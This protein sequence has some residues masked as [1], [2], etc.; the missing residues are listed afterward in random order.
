M[1]RQPDQPEGVDSED[2]SGRTSSEHPMEEEEQAQQHTYPPRPP[3]AVIRN[4]G[5]PWATGFRRP[6]SHT[7]VPSVQHSIRAA[8]TATPI[9]G[10]RHSARDSLDGSQVAYGTSTQARGSHHTVSASGWDADHWSEVNQPVQRPV[11]NFA[12]DFANQAASDQEIY[13]END[14]FSRY[15]RAR[16][17]E[18]R[19][20]EAG[21]VSATT[22]VN[23]STINSPLPLPT[24]FGTES[25]PW[26]STVDII[27]FSNDVPRQEE[28]DAVADRPND[29]RLRSSR[30]VATDT[31]GGQAKQEP[32]R[33]SSPRP[34]PE[35]AG[36]STQPRDHQTDNIRPGRHFS[37]RGGNMG[38]G[39]R[40]RR[41]GGR[42]GRRFNQG[43][44]GPSL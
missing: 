40:D 9:P 4:E 20:R 12:A 15:L 27:I 23:T 26:A 5:N 14:L 10:T 38:P 6:R 25:D 41:Q 42:R 32:G 21:S 30:T 11:R 13:R 31:A 33:E 18:Q 16:E 2:I 7:P 3:P 8:R 39:R 28:P 36:P 17:Q 22:L 37:S 34:G 43:G 24:P 29:S 35:D 1:S 44:W 19:R